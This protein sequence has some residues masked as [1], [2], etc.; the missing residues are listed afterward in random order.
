[1]IIKTPY[2]SKSKLNQLLVVITAL[3]FGLS[4]QHSKAQD[5]QIDV[6]DDLCGSLVEFNG[7]TYF[8]Y[9]NP[10]IGPEIH[11]SDGSQFGVRA[12]GDLSDS[13]NRASILFKTG[14]HLYFATPKTKSENWTVWQT[15]G[16]ESEPRAIGQLT[17]TQDNFSFVSSYL[18]DINGQHIIWD[19]FRVYAVDPI[20]S[21]VN[22]VV[23]GTFDTV[24]FDFSFVKVVRNYVYYIA[25]NVDG[26]GF[27][28]MRSSV[29]GLKQEV[30]STPNRGFLFLSEFTVNN[31]LILEQV[32]DDTGDIQY[33]VSDGTLSRSGVTELQSGARQILGESNGALLTVEFVDGQALLSKTVDMVNFTTIFD[34]NA[35]NPERFSLSD[36]R[37]KAGF[38]YFRVDGQTCISNGS[39]SR[40]RCA[41][42]P[43]PNSQDIIVDDGSY[44]TVSS[45]GLLLIRVS[46]TGFTRILHRF[47]ERISFFN[48]SLSNYFVVT[49][50][51]K[52]ATWWFVAN[53]GSRVEKL[54]SNSQFFYTELLGVQAQRVYA[55]VID[56]GKGRFLWHSDGTAKGT[57]PLFYSSVK[58]QQFG[59]LNSILFL[60]GDE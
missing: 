54:I 18:G 24:G 33:W 39:A 11:V 58:G 23:S 15:S 3:I 9:N 53:N 51:E 17:G 47:S 30:F 45:S 59:W 28:L 8:C 32:L 50:P 38:I 55:S 12:L 4:A 29:D 40:T 16:G 44:I 19:G 36:F 60:L 35:A 7:L 26:V 42:V 21:K 20:N 41:N 52:N 37:I 31:K 1:M 5:I 46:S 34:L 10:D 27:R 14:S 13:D 6:T 2:F 43:M 57:Y 48:R 49:G 25:R 56:F 22:L